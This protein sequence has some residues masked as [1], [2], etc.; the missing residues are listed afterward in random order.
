[1]VDRIEHP[2]D[3]ALNLERM[4]NGDLAVEQVANG[5]RDDRLAIAR[6]AVDEHRVAGIDRRSELVEHPI[7]DHEVGKGLPHAFSRIALAAGPRRDKRHVL[8][9]LRE[10]HWRHAHVMTGLEEQRGAGAARVGDPVAVR[11]AA[12]DAAADDLALL[13]CLQQVERWSEHRERQPSRR[14]SSVPDSSPTKCSDFSTSC[15]IRSRPSPA[16]RE[17]LRRGWVRDDFS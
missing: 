12:D 16:L 8:L 1:M 17:R 13:L 10:G 4:R 6:R 7:A 2:D 3:V 9:I 14:E 11:R 15:T 5:L